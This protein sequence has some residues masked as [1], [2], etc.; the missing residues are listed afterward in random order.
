MQSVSIRVSNKENNFYYSFPGHKLAKRKRFVMH[1]TV[2]IVAGLI[3]AGL[4]AALIYAL[5][6]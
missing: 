1:L 2:G 5:G 6:S 3:T 4:L